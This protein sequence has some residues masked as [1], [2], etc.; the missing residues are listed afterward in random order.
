MHNHT[1]SNTHTKTQKDVQIHSPTE[2]H[3]QIHFQ[4][5]RETQRTHTITITQAEIQRDQIHKQVTFVHTGHTGRHSDHTE[6]HRTGGSSQSHLKAH[7]HAQTYA[8]TNT[9]RPVSADPCP[10]GAFPPPSGTSRKRV[11]RPLSNLH[12]VNSQGGPGKTASH[13]RNRLPSGARPG[14]GCMGQSQVAWVLSPSVT[15]THTLPVHMYVQHMH[16]R[17]LLEPQFLHP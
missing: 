15:H 11:A 8:H 10:V 3:I 13:R 4:T 2:M 9:G 5:H 1:Q 16:A 14:G 17:A 6:T 12:V 7:T